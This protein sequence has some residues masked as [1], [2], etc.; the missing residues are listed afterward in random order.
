[1][2][3]WCNC[4]PCGDEWRSRNAYK[5]EDDLDTPYKK[6]SRKTYNRKGCKR[7]KDGKHSFTKPVQVYRHIW[8]YN[9]DTCKGDYVKTLVT[10]YIC[11]FCTKPNYR[12]YW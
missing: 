7:S 9:Y 2:H 3:S 11:E 4:K 6:A 10:E 1:M 12:R 5:V 8:T